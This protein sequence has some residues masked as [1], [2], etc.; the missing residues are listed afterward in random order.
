MQLE[1]T[2]SK[3]QGLGR[4]LLEQQPAEILPVKL[5]IQRFSQTVVKVFDP[6][7]RRGHNRQIDVVRCGEL[8]QHL[9][10]FDFQKGSPHS[11]G[12]PG[13]WAGLSL[14]PQKALGGLN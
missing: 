1:H 12:F 13:R 3:D 11:F 14:P 6:L 8:F 5:W 9:H 4:H 2:L 7:E 10:E